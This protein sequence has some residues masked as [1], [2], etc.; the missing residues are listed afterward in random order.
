MILIVTSFFPYKYKENW[1][2]PEL[3]GL[4]RHGKFCVLARTSSGKKTHSLPKNVQEIKVPIIGLSGLLECL[5]NVNRL[6]SLAKLIYTHSNNILDFLKRLSLL[7]KALA[8]VKKLRSIGI[9]H[10]HVHTTSSPATLGLVIAKLL[11]VDFS[12]TVHTSAQLNEK[13]RPN[14][15]GLMKHAKF[16]RTISN[17]TKKEL[18]EFATNSCPIHTVRM[19]VDI[20]S[21]E[22]ISSN[23]NYDKHNIIIISVL[24]E[25]KGIDVAI[26]AIKE[27][28]NDYPNV[29]VDIYGEGSK[30]NSLESLV[31]VNQLDNI[32]KFKGVIP[33]KKIMSLLS[34]P[35]NYNYLL[36]ASNKYS[37]QVEGIP[38]SI[39]EAMACYLIPI[40]VDSGALKELVDESCGVIANEPCHEEL[41]DKIRS[42]FETSQQEKQAMAKNAKN[43]IYKDY[44]SGINS[45]KLFETL[46]S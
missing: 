15:D 27:L 44:N 2:Y 30:R 11:D 32:I 10:V 5:I 45:L 13:F 4:S 23:K 6:P 21:F 16:V 34:E 37:G 1:I 35:G 38:V 36:L 7:P 22:N 43:I 3:K 46:S 18:Q 19:G 33:H 17:L 24:E 31:S 25:Y 42:L 39:M 40:A 8:S 28:V 12:F 20:D 29:K 41:T 14:Y 26:F 9:N